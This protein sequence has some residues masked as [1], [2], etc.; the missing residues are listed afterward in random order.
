MWAVPEAEQKRACV[1][2][3]GLWELERG[4][5]QRGVFALALLLNP[6]LGPGGPVGPVWGSEVL[7]ADP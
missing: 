6:G 1:R 7:P 5:V 4:T 2:D 3:P